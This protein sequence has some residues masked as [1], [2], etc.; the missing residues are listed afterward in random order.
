MIKQSTILIVDDESVARDILEGFLFREGYDLVFAADGAEALA[1]VEKSPP[2][3]ILL[4]V[5]LPGM[6]GFEICRRLKGDRRWRH[7]PIILVTALGGKEDLIRGLDAGADDFLRKPVND[8]ELRARVRSLLRIKQ[9]YD[10]LQAALM[11]R[12]DLAHMIV[13][14]MRTPLSAIIGYSELLLLQSSM[15]PEYAGTMD[16]IHTQARRLNSFM[17][18]MLMVAKMEADQLVLNPIPV[19][20]ALLLRGVKESHE[21]IA[22]SKR[23][24]FDLDLPMEQQLVA[25][26]NTLFQRVLDNL[27]TNALKYSPAYSTIT[28]KLEY[29]ES[30]STFDR[31]FQ[32]RFQI[33]DQGAG[34]AEEDRERIFNKYEIATL[35]QR[36]SQVGLGLAFCK[37]VVDAHR[38]RIWVEANQPEGSV[39]VVEI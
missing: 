25:V 22:R 26:D 37:M 19:D 7:I 3:A 11:M 27:V 39:F 28:L 1:S 16:K 13:H 18:D 10:E 20:I 32:F 6:D 15:P 14:D 4:D 34:I 9:Q 35:K 12:E 17:N 21:V 24:E 30:A 2:D 33:L 29:P 31:A 38:G 8:L 5:M 23:I 36:G